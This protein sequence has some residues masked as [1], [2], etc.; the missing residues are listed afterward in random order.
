MRQTKIEN[1]ANLGDRGLPLGSWDCNISC[2]WLW[3]AILAVVCLQTNMNSELVEYLLFIFK[4]NIT[5]N[6]AVCLLMELL[7]K[8]D[9][10]W[11]QWH[12]GL[13]YHQVACTGGMTL[14]LSTL[15]RPLTL[16]VLNGNIWAIFH[17]R[18]WET[19][20]IKNQNS[21]NKW[22]KAQFILRNSHLNS[23]SV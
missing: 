20:R 5:N 8:L 14:S 11:S 21:N 22:H 23:R 10:L 4:Y 2:I 17:Q 7:G 12:T 9:H 3:S 15:R 1:R 19:Y 13:H 6:F 18:L 16:L